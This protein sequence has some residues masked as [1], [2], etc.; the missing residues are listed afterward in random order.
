MEHKNCCIVSVTVFLTGQPAPMEPGASLLAPGNG[1][2]WVINVKSR[3]CAGS[4]QLPLKLVIH[5]DRLRQSNTRRQLGGG[6]LA[7]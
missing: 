1:R 3:A 4:K 6:D 2:W 7:G 5:A